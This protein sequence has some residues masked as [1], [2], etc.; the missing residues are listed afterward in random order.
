MLFYMDTFSFKAFD[1]L[2]KKK[3]GTDEYVYIG[4][5]ITAEQETPEPEKPKKKKNRC[6]SPDCK[7]KLGLMPFSCKCGLSFCMKH[8]L[9]DSHSCTY[10]FKSEAQDRLRR[11]NPQIVSDKIIKI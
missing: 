1:E 8:R 3:P 9:P 5:Q 7:K 10:D 2:W 11:D 6:S 4:E